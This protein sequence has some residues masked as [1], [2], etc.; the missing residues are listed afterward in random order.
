MKTEELTACFVFAYLFKINNSFLW[1]G[2]CI[3]MF[4]LYCFCSFSSSCLSLVFRK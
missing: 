1:D 4:L 2:F 3:Y